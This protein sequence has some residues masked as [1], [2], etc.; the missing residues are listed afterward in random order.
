MK[1][2]QQKQ[3]SEL[4]RILIFV[5]TYN[6]AGNIRELLN[7]IWDKIPHA[8]ILAVDDNS[9]DGTGVILNNIAA[10]NKR[11]KVIHRPR[12]LGLGTAH[13]L[14]MIFAIKNSYDILITM[15]ADHSHNPADLPTMINKLSESDFI[16]GS[17]YMRGG[18]CDYGGYRQFLSVSA[19]FAARLLLG[20][21]LHEFTTSYRA[22]RVEALAKVNFVKMH[23]QG[24]SFFMESVYRLKQAGLRLSETPINFRHRNAGVSKIP[25]LEIFRGMLKLLHLVSS[26]LLRRKMP[27]PRPLI[28]DLCVNCHDGFLSE[29]YPSQLKKTPEQIKSDTFRCSSMTHA[30]KPCLAKCLHCGLIQVPQVEHPKDLEDLYADVVDHHYL[31]NLHAKRKTFARAYQAIKSY[32]PTKGNLLEVGSYCG[33]FLHEAKKQGWNVTGIEPSKWAANHAQTHFK[34]EIYNG[35]LEKVA[36]ALDKEFDAVVTWDVL[37]HVRNPAEYLKIINKLLKDGGTVALSTIDISSWFPRLAGRNWPWIMEMHLFYFDTKV[38]QH[39]FRQAGFELVDTKSYCHYASL[40][41]IYRKICGIF[42]ER[43]SRIFLKAD[44]LIPQWVIPVTLG[45]IKLYVGKKISALDQPIGALSAS[46]GAK[47]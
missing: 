36:P 40:R 16:I 24:Y 30:N 3:I 32:F 34:H 39:I 38:L 13:H 19:N 7:D 14:A 46:A 27:A 35:N 1:C 37:E 8:D 29:Y 9:P 44:K 2:V 15:D 33:L 5:A 47:Q 21:P 23:N 28:E 18:S 41:Y 31:E 26:R 45:D 20:I 12:K 25:R 10:A 4:N 42:P 22:F 43:I 11:L 6:E 17:R